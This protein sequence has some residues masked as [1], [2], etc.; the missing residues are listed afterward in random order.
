MRLARVLAGVRH[1]I[2]D[3]HRISASFFIAF[4]AFWG[5]GLT[6]FTRDSRCAL[7]FV[8]MVFCW[9]GMDVAV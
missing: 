2:L 8:L 5:L 9:F 1:D 6:T 4:G 7:L 3:R